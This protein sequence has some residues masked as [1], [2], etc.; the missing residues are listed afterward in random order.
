[1]VQGPRQLLPLPR[2]PRQRPIAS[3]CLVL[4]LSNVFVINGKK[5]LE[6]RPHVVWRPAPVPWQAVFPNGRKASPLRRY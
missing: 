2:S 4:L 5:R 6:L 1:M 3:T